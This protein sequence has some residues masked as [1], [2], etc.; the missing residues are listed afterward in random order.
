M[1]NLFVYGTLLCEDIFVTVSG[2]RRRS[3]YCFLNDYRR[4]R[5][6][7]EHYPGIIP[8]PGNRVEGLLYLAVPESAWGRLDRF[9]G[10]MYHRQP[11]EVE[12]HGGDLEMAFA[13]TVRPEFLPCLEPRE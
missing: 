12:L 8:L 9:E 1:N 10:K 13:Y 7:G 2:C 11:V 5:V 6:S 4:L 3:K